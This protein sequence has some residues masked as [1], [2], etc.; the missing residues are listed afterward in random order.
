MELDMIVANAED[1]NPSTASVLLHLGDISGRKKAI[2]RMIT[3]PAVLLDMLEEQKEE[4]D[5]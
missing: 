5:G 1:E 3:L 4:K 2:D